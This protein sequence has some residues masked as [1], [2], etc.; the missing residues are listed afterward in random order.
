VRLSD[1]WAGGEQALACTAVPGFPN[2]FVLNGPN[3]GLGAGSI[4]FMIETQLSYVLGAL[5]H[6]AAY[7]LAEPE[8]SVASAEPASWRSILA[9]EAGRMRRSRAAGPRVDRSAFAGFRFPAEVITVA[10]R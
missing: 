3:V 8:G 4:V 1:R 5:Q 9:E 7:D 10:V 2:L 6:T